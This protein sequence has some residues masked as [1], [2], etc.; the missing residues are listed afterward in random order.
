[1]KKMFA[2]IGI[3]AGLVA[4]FF[5]GRNLPQLQA[6]LEDWTEEEEDPDVVIGMSDFDD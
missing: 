2:I 6:M 3:A 5:V 1:M 4:A